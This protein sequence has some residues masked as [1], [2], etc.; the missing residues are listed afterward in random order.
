M[1][2]SGIPEKLLTEFRQKV[3][4]GFVAK[5]IKPPARGSDEEVALF[6][7]WVEGRASLGESGNE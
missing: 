7:K 6:N 2:Y 5:G 4:G 3:I 1:S